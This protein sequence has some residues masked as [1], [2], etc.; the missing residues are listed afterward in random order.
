MH[1]NLRNALTDL[2]ADFTNALQFVP[3]KMYT[4]HFN[5]FI[6]E[7][8]IISLKNHWEE[9]HAKHSICI[10]FVVCNLFLNI[11]YIHTKAEKFWIS[12]MVRMGL[13]SCFLMIPSIFGHSFNECCTYSRHPFWSCLWVFHIPNKQCPSFTDAFRNI[14]KPNVYK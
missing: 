4:F 12:N 3:L 5:R 10:Q 13:E 7:N 9:P 8:D 1:A 6:N 2:N 11:S 14:L